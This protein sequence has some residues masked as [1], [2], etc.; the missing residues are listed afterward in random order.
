MNKYYLVFLLISLIFS[1]GI[2]AAAP[3]VTPF[4]KE[5][6]QRILKATQ[7][8]GIVDEDLLTLIL[9]SNPDLNIRDQVYNGTPLYWAAIKN[10]PT[11]VKIL[12][13]Y[14]AKVNVVDKMG[15]TPLMGA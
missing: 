15:N 5:T 14:S 4:N 13:N 8:F 11:T 3:K 1:E 7:K 9:K 6:G 2:Y 12:L 10:R